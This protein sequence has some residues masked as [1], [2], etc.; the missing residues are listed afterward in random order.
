VPI[1]QQRSHF[2]ADKAYDAA[3]FVNE[4][5]AMNVMPHVA[6]NNSGRSSAVDE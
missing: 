3:D 1:D 6:H 4:L 5:R 2:G